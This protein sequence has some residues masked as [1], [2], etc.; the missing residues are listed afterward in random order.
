MVTDVDDGT[1]PDEILPEA[2]TAGALDIA[3]DADGNKLTGSDPG[4]QEAP[5]SRTGWAPK[6]GLG[7]STLKSES[8]L[9]HSTWLEGRLPDNLYGGMQ[10]FFWE[11]QLVTRRRHVANMAAQI[12]IT[13][14]A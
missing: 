6:F 3:K 4:A 8:L 14:R 2:S 7:D 11:S 9:D 10:N 13:T 1:G 12:G 5:Y